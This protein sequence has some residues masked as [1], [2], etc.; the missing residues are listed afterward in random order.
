MPVPPPIVQDHQAN[1]RTI[2][3]TKEFEKMKPP[4]FKGGI[5]PL[6]VKAWVLGIEKLFKVFPCT[7]AQKV[8][9]T[10]FT[11]E[12]KACRWWMFIREEHQGMN[13]AQFLDVFYEKHRPQSIRDR[14]VSEFEN[15]KQGN[16]TVAEYETKFTEL[17]R[18]ALHLIDTDYKKARK[19]EGGLRDSILEKINVLKVQKYVDVLDRAIIVESNQANRKTPG[20]WDCQ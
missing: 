6:K 8:L 20:Q 2:T 7:E 3:L 15:L 11:L 4:S 19:F 16:K 18:F 9:L 12:D 17:A 5:D 1:D 13:W 14:K 10:T